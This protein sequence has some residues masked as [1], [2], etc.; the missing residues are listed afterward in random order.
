[1]FPPAIFGVL[2]A[3]MLNGVECGKCCS[4]FQVNE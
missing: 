2:A 4:Q 1:M 3:L